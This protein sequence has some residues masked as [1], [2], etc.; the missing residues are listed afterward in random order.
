MAYVI[1]E[2]AESDLIEIFSYIAGD[3]TAAALELINRFFHLFGLLSDEP[4]AG[5]ERPELR[6]GLRSFPEGR[7][8]IFYRILANEDVEIIRVLHSA[9]DIDTIFAN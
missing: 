1:T 7:Y 3:N 8:V 6:P 5:R 9:R 2:P 4:R